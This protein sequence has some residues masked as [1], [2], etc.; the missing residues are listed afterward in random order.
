V[1]DIRTPQGEIVIEIGAQRRFL[2]GKRQI[3]P[4]WAYIDK[5]EIIPRGSIDTGGIISWQTVSS[6]GNGKTLWMSLGIAG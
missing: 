6:G 5:G 2:L 3:A 1:F 4:T